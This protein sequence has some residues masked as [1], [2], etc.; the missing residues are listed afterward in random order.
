MLFARTRKSIPSPFSLALLSIAGV[1]IGL[2]AQ[3]ITPVSW[4]DLP[5]PIQQRLERAGLDRAGFPAWTT[6]LRARHAAR[7][8]EGDEDHL[9]FY[10]LQST[11]ITAAEPIEPALSARTLVSSLDADART[12]FFANPDTL[13]ADRIPQDA[14]ARLRALVRAVE[15]ESTDERLGYFRALLQTTA[16]PAAPRRAPREAAQARVNRAYLRAMRF[17]AEQDRAGQTQDA[18][19][20]VATLYRTRGL[21]TDTSIEA[22]FLIR[23][24]LATLRALEPERRIH[25][26]VI[27]GPGLDLAPR[28]GLQESIPPQSVQPFAVADALVS[29]GLADVA[30]LRITCLDINPRVVRALTRPQDRPLTLALSTNVASSLHVTLSEEFR[31]YVETL[32]QEIGSPLTPTTSRRVAVAPAVSRAIAARELDIVLDR[33]PIEADLVVITNVL[34]YLDDRELTMALANIAAM[35]SPGG[36]LL[37]NEARTEVG[38][39]TTALGLPLAQSR[40]AVLATLREAPPLYDSVFIHVRRLGA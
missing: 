10:A 18:A 26:V 1:A 38:A 21:S 6:G 14:R 15:T 35:L 8:L 32:G 3:S 25:R 27:V 16:A 19:G 4:T 34:P 5:A 20:A 22:G 11:R 2:T 39:I 13:T 33:V 29:L 23:E 9:V 36:V 17:L 40:T 30:S 7:V 24:G 31:R 12:R 37:H 28:T